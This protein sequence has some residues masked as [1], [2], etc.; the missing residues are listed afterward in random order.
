MCHSGLYPWPHVVLCTNLHREQGGAW[1]PLGDSLWSR[2]ARALGTFPS[3][4]FKISDSKCRTQVTEFAMYVLGNSAAFTCVEPLVEQRE[5]GFRAQMLAH[6][7][8]SCFTLS[9]CLTLSSSQSLCY[10]YVHKYAL[11]C[12]DP[13]SSVW[14]MVHNTYSI[15][16]SSG[17]SRM[18]L[19]T[20]FGKYCLGNRREEYRTPRLKIRFYMCLDDYYVG[21]W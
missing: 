2:C 7:F 8:S 6:M 12:E 9:S 13:T 21:L 10:S 15:T 1:W 11:F 18:G 14:L 16:L 3:T 17:L 5:L 4:L 20:K 19:I